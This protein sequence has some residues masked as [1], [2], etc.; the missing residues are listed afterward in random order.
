MELEAARGEE[1]ESEEE[2]ACLLMISRKA[3]GWCKRGSFGL[4]KVPIAKRKKDKVGKVNS[5]NR[6]DVERGL[7]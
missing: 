5:L 2:S 7:L 6:Y 1:A 3:V 4:Q